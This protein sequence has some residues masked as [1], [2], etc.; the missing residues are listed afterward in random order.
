MDIGENVEPG[1]ST[2]KRKR[3]VHGRGPKT[4]K[5]CRGQW[6]EEDMTMDLTDTTNDCIEQEVGWDY[7]TWDEYFE[8]IVVCGCFV[9]RGKKRF[10]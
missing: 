2:S 8:K 4:V 7:S 3:Y 9:C 10:K 6:V 5:S 1:H